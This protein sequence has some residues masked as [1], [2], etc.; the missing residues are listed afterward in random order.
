MCNEAI[1]LL[2]QFVK[3]SRQYAEGA[4]QLNSARKSPTFDSLLREIDVVRHSCEE[5]NGT[6]RSHLLSHRCHNPREMPIR[7]KSDGFSRELPR[8]G[9]NTPP[10]NA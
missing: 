10:D 6:L 5:A 3:I 1:D 2:R 8:L 7:L 9:I 4:Q